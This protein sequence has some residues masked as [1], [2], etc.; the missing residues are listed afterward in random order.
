MTT[1]DKTL[2]RLSTWI[3]VVL[4]LSFVS[5]VFLPAR[6]PTPATGRR[7]GVPTPGP[8]ASSASAPSPQ[9]S[10]APVSSAQ[11]PDSQNPSAGSDTAPAIPPPLTTWSDAEQTTA[12]RECLTLLA[13][14]A[15]DITLEVPV[16]QGQCG[17]AAP[18]RLHALGGAGKVAFEPAPEMNCKLAAGLSRW[19][20]TVMQPAAREVLG[21]RIV[22]IIGASSYACRN[23]YNRAVGPLSEHATGNAVD[24]AGF[25]TTDGRTITVGKGWGPTERDIVE[26]KR[27]TAEAAKRAGKADA[28][29]ADDKSSEL[30]E[31]S[32]KAADAKEPPAE[33]GSTENELEGDEPAAAPLLGPAVTQK[34][35]RSEVVPAVATATAAKTIEAAFLRRLHHGACGVFGTVLGPEANEAHRS[36][37]HFDMK[38]RKAGVVCH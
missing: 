7:S 6:G 31:P 4:V 29:K 21:A 2:A 26:A 11:A 36:H 34:A 16:R 19:V 17:A 8:S 32:D 1:V 13:P 14:L 33:T 35:A 9:A 30:Q 38:D 28:K 3:S 5:L 15:A 18:L 37:F 25:V 24:I 23:I 27:K 12:L 22:R 10:S 20:E